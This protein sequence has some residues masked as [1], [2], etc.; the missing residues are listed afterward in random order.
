MSSGI[1]MPMD[2]QIRT[3]TNDKGEREIELIVSH[4][5]RPY[6][7]RQVLKLPQGKPTQ[8]DIA[9]LRAARPD[10]MPSLSL[11]ANRHIA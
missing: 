10:Y 5:A 11:I 1:L 7:T 4:H 9:Y 3:R 8:E 6:L 2:Q